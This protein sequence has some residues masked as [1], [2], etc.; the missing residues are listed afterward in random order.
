LQFECEKNPLLDKKDIQRK[1]SKLNMK[2]NK[3]NSMLSGPEGHMIMN[4]EI[5]TNIEMTN[6]AMEN[7][8]NPQKI[9]H[10]APK[11]ISRELE[12]VLNEQES[13]ENNERNDQNNGPTE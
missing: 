7:T 11:N 4:P 13:L 3:K 6:L 12:N 8:I 1:K 2:K 5:K 10:R 9:R